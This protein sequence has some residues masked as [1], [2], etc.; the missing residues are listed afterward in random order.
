M[1]TTTLGLL[2]AALLAAGGLA[3][4]SG[5]LYLPATLNPANR[6]LPRF[7]IEPFSSANARLQAFYDAKEVGRSSFVATELA[8]RWDGPLPKVGAPGPFTIDRLRIRVGVS[9][10][11]FPGPAFDANLTTAPVV[12]FDGKHSYWPD[13]GVMGVGPWGGPKGTLRFPFKNPVKVTIPKGGWLVIEITTRNNSIV[14]AFAHTILDAATGTGGPTNGSAKSFG[15]G[16]AAGSGSGPAVV[17]TAGLHAPGASFSLHGDRL[18][19]NAPVVAVLGASDKTSVFGPLPFRVPGT[20]C[21]IYTSWE[22]FVTMRADASGS[23]SP[24]APG[25]RIA[26]PS[27]KAFDGARVFAQ[28]VSLVPGANAPWGLV[29][30]DARAITLGRFSTPNHGFA[31]VADSTSA[32]AVAADHVRITGIAM[33][34][35]VQ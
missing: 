2:T 19:P 4:Q 26:V 9:A 12:V 8:L 25:S 11:P 28:L 15:L 16:C 27:D 35:K 13:Q 6:D 22:A 5:F 17:K 32:A 3:Q 10:V 34:L 31:V 1:R 33:R 7:S 29:F 20:S 14:K 18:G 30:S 23:I 21:R 24:N